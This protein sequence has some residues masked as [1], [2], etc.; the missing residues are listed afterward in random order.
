MS[1]FIL[2]IRKISYIKEEI[3]MVIDN[4]EELIRNDR[5]NFKVLISTI[6][7]TISSIKILLTSRNI[8]GSGIK[9]A[10]EEIVVLS[11]LNTI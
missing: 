5:Q 2:I 1:T 4:C 3:L 7:A 9:E 11:G 6:L 10:N 8:I